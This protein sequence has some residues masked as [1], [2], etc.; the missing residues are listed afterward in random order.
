MLSVQ[1][2]RGARGQENVWHL[3]YVYIVRA[4]VFSENS[5][6]KVWKIW[7]QW[8]FNNILTYLFFPYSVWK[9]IG[10][11][12]GNLHQP[13]T[14]LYIQSSMCV[15]VKI[16][17]I[18]IKGCIAC[19]MMCVIFA[20]PQVCRYTYHR[21]N[22]RSYHQQDIMLYLKC[23]MSLIDQPETSRILCCT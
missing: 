3:F 7:V 23:I 13:F 22:T 20:S 2:A 18:R 19:H 14:Y 1:I 6:I 21:H 16:E 12:Y 5:K 4:T 9:G 10:F 17:A 11:I 8:A 15:L